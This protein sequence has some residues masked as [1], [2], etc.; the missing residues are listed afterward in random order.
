[1]HNLQEIYSNLVDKK[2]RGSLVTKENVIF[3]NSYEGTPTAGGTVKIPV[4][5]TEVEVKEYDKSK[6][7]NLSNS[8]TTYIDLKL[9]ND[10]AVNEIIDGYDAS[11]VPDGI[12]AE[13]IDS[14]GYSLGLAIDKK[15][16]KELE[17]TE[18]VTIATSKAKSTDAN[19]FK[20]ALD[21]KTALSRTGVPNDGLRWLI[22][23]PEFTALLMLDDKFIKQGDLSQELVMQGAIGKIAGFVVYESN[24]TMFNN[25]NFVEGKRVTTEFICGHP[26]WCHRVEAWQV[27]VEIK[28]L[29]NNYIGSSAVQGRKVYGLKISKPE[30]VYIKRIEA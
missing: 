18:G 11:A 28:N 17:E 16:I 6:G 25:E 1:M 30:T 14:A 19:A 24:N 23:S 12:V 15:S 10:E 5:D 27:P 21:A 22:A 4:R 20:N 2:L 26:N 3:N 8:N 7:V 9:N 29:T 13:R